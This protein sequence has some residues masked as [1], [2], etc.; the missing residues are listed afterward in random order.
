M[1]SLNQKIIIFAI[2]FIGIEASLHFAS[3]VYKQAQQNH[4]EDLS[5]S[6]FVIL[7][8]GE[9]TTEW[10]GEYSYPAQLEK[11]LRERLP[12]KNIR[13][14]NGGKTGSDTRKLLADLPML[15]EK[16][17]PKI[18]TTMT[19]INDYWSLGLST[20]EFKLKEWL[21]ENFKIYRFLQIALINL[22][23]ES[24]GIDLSKPTK[25][26]PYVRVPQESK[27]ESINP[28]QT[29]LLDEGRKAIAEKN[30]SKLNEV[31]K[32]LEGNSGK[33]PRFTNY[34]K[35][36]SYLQSE[37]QNE[38][39]VSFKKYTE[40]SQSSDVSFSIGEFYYF[41]YGVFDQVN[42][43]RA[44]YFFDEALRLDPSNVKALYL[45]GCGIVNTQ[46]T[47]LDEA[48]SLLLKSWE[49]G[50]RHTD[51][52]GCIADVYLKKGDDI[53]AEKFLLEGIKFNQDT[54]FFI[55]NRLIQLYMRTGRIEDAKKY[56]QIAMSIYPN[57]LLHEQWRKELDSHQNTDQIQTGPQL[58]TVPD[59]LN[60]LANE[61][62]QKNLRQMSDIIQRS[63]ALHVAVQ[64]PTL[65]LE[66]LFNLFGKEN[67][68]LYVDNSSDFDSMIKDKGFDFLFID[69]FGGTFGHT[70]PEG[71]KII[72]EN[73][74]KILLE[75]GLAK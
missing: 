72:A 16:Y 68:V 28:E 30:Y 21:F 69:R 23:S 15:I 64:Y 57:T 39:L 32:S 44:F 1:K 45:K 42:L 46:A 14:I 50:E 8:I 51:Q 34:L 35:A 5:G 52:I 18:V 27:P 12:D 22:I 58:K 61:V 36:R 74:A 41:R 43:E 3:F 73:I 54:T 66:P 71:S 70:T 48:L 33:I 19:G 59:Q 25:D 60:Y 6:E 67:D 65:S 2:C 38:A 47:K 49:I 56:L 10:G 37:K 4:H 29:L 62:T 40:L 26:R 7:S 20:D 24:E 31:I 17:N 63:G 13:V 75:S 9:S 53:N 11:I 55:Y